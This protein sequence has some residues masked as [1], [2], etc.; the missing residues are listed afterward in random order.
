MLHKRL[1]NKIS[2]I[3]STK[4]I[5]W[6]KTQVAVKCFTEHR[7]SYY[8]QLFKYVWYWEIVGIAMSIF[9]LFRISGDE[10]F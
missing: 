4:E 10:H 6:K 8:P 9:V 3:L 5:L 7:C 2:H 1:P